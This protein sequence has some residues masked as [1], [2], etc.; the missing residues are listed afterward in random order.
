MVL[1]ALDHSRDF[2]SPTAFDPLD[3]SETTP[4]WYLARWI[5]NFCA[6]VFVF[7]AGTAAWYKGRKVGRV[8]LSRWLVLRGFWLILA[9]VLLNNPIWFGNAWGTIGW[10]FSLQVLWAIGVSMICLGGLCRL[11]P[12]WAGIVAVAMILGHNLLDGVEVA[13]F[14]S[15]GMR[16]ILWALVHVNTL[17]P[18]AGR[19]VVLIHYPVVPWIGVLAAGWVWG[20]W[21][22]GRARRAR[23]SLLLGLGLIAAFVLI[24]GLNVYGDPDP[25]HASDRSALHTLM[26]FMDCEKY[27]PSLSFLLMTL[28]PALVVLSLFERLPE[29]A[30]RILVVFGRVP[31]FF[32]LLHVLVINAGAS[33]MALQAGRPLGWWWIASSGPFAGYE[34]SLAPG[35]IGWV[36]VVAGLYWPCVA[37]G[38]LKARRRHGWVDLF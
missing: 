17:V 10:F 11:R 31:M 14:G 19:A 9:E 30:L 3:G 37:W 28:G 20:G 18:V 23:A 36:L 16:D 21:F 35:L 5:T 34:P 4:T 8:A 24:R 6:P 26:S 2:F 1:M 33:A 7:L 22:E 15:Q 12:I 13:P 38:R 27:P 25:W 29:R 32:Y